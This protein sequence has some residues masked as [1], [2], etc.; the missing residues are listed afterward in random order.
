ML[1]YC[2]NVAHPRPT[3]L[4]TMFGHILGYYINVY[5]FFGAFAKIDFLS[6]SCVLLYWQR[7]CRALRQQGQPN[8]AVSYKEW[9]YGTFAEVATYIRLGSHHV[10]HRPTF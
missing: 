7:Y 4:C 6:K 1:R 3:K 2:S 10:G 9:N 8:F 5:T